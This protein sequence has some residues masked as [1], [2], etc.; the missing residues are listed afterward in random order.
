MCEKYYRIFSYSEHRFASALTS[1]SLP[2]SP[3]LAPPSPTPQKSAHG[4]SSS[5]ARPTPATAT[6][7]KTTPAGCAATQTRAPC[8]SSAASRPSLTGASASPSA[9]PSWA[10]PGPHP[11]RTPSSSAYSLTQ[12]SSLRWYVLSSDTLTAASTA[13]SHTLTLSLRAVASYGNSPISPPS[14]PSATPP[15]GTPDSLRFYMPP[16]STLL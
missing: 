11:Q 2:S 13:T 14:P 4:L 7:T 16:D 6:P 9:T 15:S 8:T 1:P 12:P 10:A 3:R 5:T